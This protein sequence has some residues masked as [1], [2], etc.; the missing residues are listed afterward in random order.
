MNIKLLGSALVAAL[1]VAAPSFGSG[2]LGDAPPVVATPI[3]VGMMQATTIHATTGAMELVSIRVPPGGS[4]GWHK[5][6]SPV[7][8]VVS[9]GTLTVFDPAVASCRPFKVSRGQ[10]F[11]EPVSH[12][13]TARCRSSSM[14]CTS[15]CRRARARTTA[16]PPRAAVTPDTRSPRSR[17]ARESG[18][19]AEASTATSAVVVVQRVEPLLVLDAREH[20]DV[21]VPDRAHLGPRVVAPARRQALPAP[22]ASG[23][24]AVPGKQAAWQPTQAVVLAGSN[25]CDGPSFGGCC[26]VLNFFETTE[27]AQRYLREHPDINGAPITV[28]EA[29]EAGRVVFGGVLS[30]D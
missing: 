28:P 27:N 16:S 23:L 4:F 10:S 14:R 2:A 5:H 12:G 15:A 3:A 13:T 30:E 20:L 24:L 18:S 9:S 11:V 6:G 22:P 1:A 29:A 8:V 21:H 25:C 19:P 26:D 17:R 7:A